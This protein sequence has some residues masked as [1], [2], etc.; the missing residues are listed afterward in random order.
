M[1]ILIVFLFVAT[2]CV[3]AENILFYWGLS[4]ISHR[5][6]VWPLVDKLVKKGHNVTFFSCFPPK[7]PNPLVTEI[8]PEHLMK[9]L[10]FD[11]DL[12]N[13]RATEGSKG[14]DKL[15]QNYIK[16]AITHCNSVFSNPELVDW[17]N[18]ASYDLVI[19]NA[20]FNDCA[21]GLVFK[22]KAPY[23][24]YGTTS[25]F[26]LWSESY[27]FP[28]E[29]YPEFTLHYPLEMTFIQR[30]INALKPLSWHWNR[31]YYM[32]PQI[33]E[34]LKN[35][36]Q[37]KDMP[38][39]SEIEQNVSLVL[40]NIHH[41]QEF[42]RSLPALFVEAGGMHCS[43][44]IKPLPKVSICIFLDLTDLYYFCMYVQYFS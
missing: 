6:S 18:N 20:F 2:N 41:S 21:Y 14:T 15:W 27:G 38:S 10:G 24:I 25:A 31:N 12:L 1:K 39:L 26:G 11:M 37:L 35:G 34:I 17:I 28:D 40:M 44:E 36:L 29:N 8:T 22:F 23:I 33:E 30:V 32:F 7:K 42:A 5:I 3:F 16:F 9:D 43:D 19:I 4:G 13:I